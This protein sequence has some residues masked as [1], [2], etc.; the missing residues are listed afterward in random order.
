MSTPG[1]S[2]AVHEDV[3]FANLSGQRLCGTARLPSGAGPF[4]VVVFAHGFHSGRHSTRN[5]QIADGLVAHGIAAFLIDFT[6]HGESEGSIEQATVEQMTGDLR[7]AVDTIAGHP[8]I[9]A[10]RIAVA[11]S[12]SGGIVALL[13]AADDSRVRVLVLRSVPA[14]GLIAPAGRVRAATRV[15]AGGDDMPI[16]VEDEVLAEAI[17]GEHD[18]VLIPGAGHLFEE[19]EHMATVARLTIEWC[20]SHLRGAGGEGRGNRA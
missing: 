8:R 13:E 3:T 9:D 15:L 5:I 4:P 12:S 18:F 7:A 17:A 2:D 10:T 11:G 1:P 19:P 16:A 20:V 6:G 14:Q